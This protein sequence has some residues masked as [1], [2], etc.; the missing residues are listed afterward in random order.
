M[1]SI[2]INFGIC[3]IPLAFVVFGFIFDSDGAKVAGFTVF[4]IMIL[5]LTIL[6]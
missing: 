3:L 4:I 6:A 5:I 1:K 2:M